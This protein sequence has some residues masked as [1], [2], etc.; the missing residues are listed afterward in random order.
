MNRITGSA[1]SRIAKCGSSVWI[2]AIREPSSRYAEIG[3]SAHSFYE[4]GIKDDNTFMEV[5][6]FKRPEERGAVG[7]NH[8]WR[9]GWHIPTNAFVA[10][11]KGEG[12]R[13]YEAFNKD[14]WVMASA[15]AVWME[16]NRL[17]V[18]DLKTGAPVEPVCEQLIFI[19]YCAARAWG[20]EDDVVLQTLNAVRY[21]YKTAPKL[22]GTVTLNQAILTRSALDA[23]W[24]EKIEGPILAAL[25]K[26]AVSQQSATPGKHCFF[27]PSKANCENY[28]AKATPNNLAYL[29]K[30]KA[31][32]DGANTGRPE[33]DLH[34]AAGPAQAHGTGG[35][36]GVLAS[37]EPPATEGG[38]E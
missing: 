24:R 22:A 25:Q 17:V 29:D 18:E 3:N 35:V 11:P 30:L 14:E 19:A 12:G 2:P 5:P 33:G 37:T 7:V 9:F 26:E 13:D 38:G 36:L 15:D 20:V 31:G 21:G 8:E 4:T 23:L 1:I 32:Q 28:R 27:C 16:Y 6:E 10:L 34:E